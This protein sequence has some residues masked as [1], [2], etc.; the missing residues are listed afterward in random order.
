V[1]NF[2]TLAL[3]LLAVA[4]SLGLMVWHVRSLRQSE[5]EVLEPA[6]RNFRQRQSRRRMQ[7]SAMLGL[8]GLALMAAPLISHRER[9]LGFLIYWTAVLAWLGWIMLMALGDAWSSQQHIRRQSRVELDRIL[10]DR[11]EVARIHLAEQNGHD[12]GAP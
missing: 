10:R 3:V 5:H 12:R 11:E 8:L 6:D 4:S 7:A 1:P 2:P 9:P